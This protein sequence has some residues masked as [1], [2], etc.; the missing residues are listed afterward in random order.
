MAGIFGGAFVALAVVI[1]VVISL[2]GGTSGAAGKPVPYKSAPGAYVTALTSI[3]ASRLA[4][5]GVGGGLASPSGVFVPTPKQPLLNDGAKPV[6]VYVGAEYCPY[7][8]A[9]RWPLVIALS[10]FGTFTGLGIIASSPYDVY[11]STRTLSFEK[12]HYS[13]PYLVFDSTE[14]TTN[15]CAVAVVANGCPNGNYTPLQ[16]TSPRDGKLFST[17]DTSPY[18]QT[19][20]GIPFLDWGGRFV[21]SGSVY[22]P[23]LINLGNST[24]ALG[25]HPMSWQE[26]IANI[27]SKPLTPAGQAILG[28]AS[29]YTGAI[30]EMTHGSP[31]SVCRTPVIKQTEAELAKT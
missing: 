25:W 22:A 7:C 31:A 15:A 28:S 5:A 30:C 11:A 23:S 27:E 8:A 26:I 14:L 3:T 9:S 24:N 2:L 29:L 16:S 18:F 21:S 12:A 6:L 17:Y 19:Q 1:I 4:A 13:S 10:R 20:G